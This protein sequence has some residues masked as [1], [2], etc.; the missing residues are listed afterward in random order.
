MAGVATDLAGIESAGDAFALFG[1]PRSM[2][3]DPAALE[4][5]YLALTRLAHP[6][7]AGDDAEA[8]I[9]AIDASAKVNAAYRALVD[10]EERA[11]LLLRLAGGPTREQ[12]KS[13]PPG[14]LAEMMETR[15]QLD[16]ALA[17]G[18]AAGVAA[19]GATARQLRGERLAAVERLLTGPATPESLAAARVELNALRY[20]E[21]MLAQ[22]EGRADE[23][24]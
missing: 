13:L 22:M 15:E 11:D 17:S 5:A 16:D 20:L 4:A 24:P 2:R 8:Q 21:R 23:R 18:D 6:D 10:E 9:R 7:F 14:F 3:L 1:V 12:D 19:L